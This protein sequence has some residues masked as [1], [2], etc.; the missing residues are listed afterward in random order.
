MA[1]LR[2]VRFPDAAAAIKALQPYDDGFMNGPLGNLYD[3]LQRPA[4]PDGSA[5]AY[6]MAIYCGDDILLTL[7]MAPTDRAWGLGCPQYARRETAPPSL[8]E[9]IDLLAKRAMDITHPLAVDM[10]YG[11]KGAVDAFFHSWLDAAASKGVRLRINDPIL[12]TRASYTTPQSVTSP[13][14]TRPDYKIIPATGDDFAELFPLYLDF[15]TYGR[16]T[17]ALDVEEAHLRFVL[18]QGN[19]WLCRVDNTLAGFVVLGRPTPNTIAI[20]HVYVAPEHRRKGIAE[21]MVRAVNRYYLGVRPVGYDGLPEGDPP[22]GVKSF[23]CLNAIDAAAENIYRRAGFLFPLRTTDEEAA[24][25]R[26]PVSGRKAWQ[27][28]V[29]RGVEP[30]PAN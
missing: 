17:R 4:P 29:L 23:I 28:S 3:N 21:G 15:T 8:K 9:A 11:E 1:G 2:F 7:T 20:R 6:Y 22:V 26:D 24:G 12:D 14:P 19:S 13:P 16:R 5:E 10:L 30:E 18:Q 25:G 27:Q